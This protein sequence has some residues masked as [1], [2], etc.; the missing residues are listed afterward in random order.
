MKLKRVFKHDEEGKPT[1]LDHIEVEH[2]GIQEAQNF[3]TGLVVEALKAGWMELAEGKLILKAEPEALKY[4]ILHEPGRYCLHCR[5]KLPDDEKG[6]LAQIHVLTEH[7]GAASPDPSNPAGYIKLNAYECM[8]DSK[9][10][11]KYQAKKIG[12]ES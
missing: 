11:A 4:T 2:T 3:S 10:H 12:A 5:E 7:L 1:E 8:L 9:Q 6:E